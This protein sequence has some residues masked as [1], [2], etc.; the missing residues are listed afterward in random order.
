MLWSYSLGKYQMYAVDD[1]NN[2]EGY[3]DIKFDYVR[4]L[5]GEDK[6][7]LKTELP[8]VPNDLINEKTLATTLND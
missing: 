7:V 4:A 6:L 5:I 2:E 3:C 1:D 8:V